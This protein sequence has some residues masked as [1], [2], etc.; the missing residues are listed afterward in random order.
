MIYVAFRFEVGYAVGAIVATL[1]DVFITVGVYVLLGGQFTSP[2]VAAVL[3]IIGYSL[4]DTVIVFDRVREELKLNPHL[5]LVQVLDLAVNKTFAR[6]TMTSMTVF[7]CLVCALSLWRRRGARVRARVHDRYRHRH[8]LLHL[9]RQPGLLLVAQRRPPPRR[10]A[11]ICPQVRVGQFD[12]RRGQSEIFGRDGFLAVPLRFYP[13]IR[14]NSPTPPTEAATAL[15]EALS[16]SPVLA[17]LLVNRGQLDAA[18]AAEFLR[19]SLASLADPFHVPHVE[20]A[21]KVLDRSITAGHKIVVFGDYDVDGVTSTALLVSILRAFGNE[22][23]YAVPRRLEEGYGLSRAA[24]ERVLADGVPGLFIALD[25]G[26]NAVEEVALLR[27]RG[28]QV[29]IVDHHRAKT[30]LPTDCLLVNPYVHEHAAAPWSHLCTVGLVFKLA[31]G[32]LKLRRAAGD[33]RAVALK[34]AASARP[35]GPWH[36]GRPRPPLTG[37]NRI[38]ARHGM[39][40]LEKC[41]RPG[42]RALFSVSGLQPGQAIAAADISYRLGP[43]INASGRL[44]DAALPVELLWL[45]NYETCRQRRRPPS[46]PSTANASKLSVK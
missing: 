36:G 38:L 22:P 29:I 31:H 34:L 14:W 12:P 15:A 26:T 44:A 25:C 24:I 46:T 8:G 43:R 5:K 27:Q 39:K 18:T 1:H 37:E 3:M 23:L 13:V 17:S 20:A 28:C 7:L 16:I 42:L 10:G 2:M 35:R 21:A 41:D 11:R 40:S 32:F 4:N 19:P 6:T 45:P 33:A 9:H 30:G